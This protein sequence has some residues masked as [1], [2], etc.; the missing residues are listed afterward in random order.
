MQLTLLDW[1]WV[2]LYFLVNGAI[3]HA[4]DYDDV[5]LAMPEGAIY[6]G[7]PSRYGNIFKIGLV[8]C[9]CRSA[10]ECRHNSFRVETAAEAVE[11]YRGWVSCWSDKARARAIA[12]LRGHDLACWCGLSAPAMSTTVSNWGT[13]DGQEADA[14]KFPP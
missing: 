11:A 4:L 1:F 9:G 14:S 3:G 2:A 7:R 5:N 8:A 10:G 12:A 6:V 13:S